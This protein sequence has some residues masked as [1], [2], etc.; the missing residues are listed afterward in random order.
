MSIDLSQFFDVFFEESFEGLDAM[1]SEL[2][3]LEPGKEDQE[4][5]N[6][7]FRAAHSIKGGS[8]TF[9]FTAV[10]DFTHVLE[11]LLDQIRNG[12]RQLTAEHVNLLLKAVDCLRAMLTALQ[13][14]QEPEQEEANELKLRFEAILNG[15]NASSSQAEEVSEPGESSSLPITFQIDFKP[16]PYLFKTGNEP[17]FMIAELAE[18]G[19]LETQVLHDELPKFKQLNPEDCYLYWRF[20]LTTTRGESAIREIFEWVEDDAEITIVQCGGLFEE[21]ASEPS[22]SD[23]QHPPGEP[24]SQADSSAL[25]KPVQ[26]IKKESPQVKDARKNAD[27]STTS[28]R[29]GIDKVDSLINMVGELVI[30][31]AMLSQIGEQEITESSIAALQEGLAQLAHNTRDLQENVMRIRMLPISFVFSRF[32]RLVRDI[33]QKLNKQVE[34]KLIGEQTELDKTVMEKLSDPMVHLVR[35]SLDHGLE[36]PE[37]RIAQGKD[38]VGT[39]TLNAFHQGGNIVIE[40]MDDG[41]GLDTEKI[42]NKAVQNGLIQ[43]M[44]ELTVDEINELIFMPGFSTADNVS[45]ISG[46]G[47]GMD[48]VRKNIQALNGSVEVSSEAG[49]G[50]TFTIRL[51]LTLAILDGQ[52]VQV[53]DHTY[54]IPLISIVESLQIDIAKV[55]NVGKGL[56][57][58]RLRDEYI[59]ILRLYDIFNHRGAREELDKTLLVVVENDNYKVG[60]LVDDLLAQ[61]QVVIKSLEANYQRVDGISGA[62]IL[63]DGTVSLIIDISGLIKLSGLR[64]PGSSEL[65]VDLKADEAVTA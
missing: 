7:I 14:Q 16:L 40:I 9:G 31:Q 56:Q 24:E 28:I 36:T 33:S 42:R 17:L 20:F 35:N 43:E 26:E 30:T 3:S 37:Q 60:I 5:I 11:T 59:P 8:G 53:A 19:E 54:I 39:V 51:P 65:L 58:L 57:V 21:P 12:E 18:L 34:L 10:S 52:L 50:S 23:T 38:P 4:T 13:A 61:Q 6:T 29:V 1:E 32:P 48:V 22:E 46:R 47:V 27:P 2:L 62:T 64:R 45:E 44:D 41:K 25:T 49:V 55:S 15:D 63:G